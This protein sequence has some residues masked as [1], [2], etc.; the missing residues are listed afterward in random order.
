MKKFLLSVL[1]LSHA[2]GALCGEVINV[3]DWGIHPNTFEDATAKLQ[4]VI[5]ACRNKPDVI[6][7]FPPGRYDFWPDKAIQKE[8]YISNTSSESDCPSKVKNIGLLFE[9]LKNITVEGNGSLFVFHGKMITLAIDRSENIEI[10]NLSIDFER[11]SMSEITIDELY[12]DSLIASV[13]PDSRYAI[14]DGKIHFYGENWSMNDNY[15][16]ILTDTIQGTNVYTSWSPIQDAKAIERSP[17][18]LKFENKFDHTNYK[19]GQTITIRK[20]IRDHVGLF[21]NRSK[22]VRMENINIHYMHGLGVVSQFS[23]NL[24]YRHINITPSRQRTIASFADGMHFS[25]C[26]GHIEIDK[27][28]F[29]GLHDD[30]VNVH[31]TYLKIEKIDNPAKLTLRFMHAQ[32]YGMQAFFVND[33]VAFIRSET[34]QKTGF[35]VVT[36]VERLS[37]REVRIELDK[38]LPKEITMGDC[39]E[40]ITC[41]PS[42][43]ISNCRMEMTNTRGLLVTTPKKVV[44]ENNHFYRTGMYA[45]QIAADANSWYESGAV[46]DVVI[47]HNTF[48]ACGYNLYGGNNHY[49]IAIEPENHKRVKNHWVHRNI[50]IR[51]NVFKVYDNHPVIRARSVENLDFGNNTIENIPLI[52]LLKEQGEGRGNN[53]AFLFDNCTRIRIHDNTYKLPNTNIGIKCINMRKSDIKNSDNQLTINIL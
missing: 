32:T 31:G 30:P 14:I 49:A 26:K 37:D 44:I 42:L 18:K 52:P 3:A 24:T 10:R 33:T 40:N 36:N 50:Y 46:Q 29:K 39:I 16:S 11:P 25:G 9:N 34:L 5:A 53:A 17:F 4:Q 47:R 7:T 2:M 27:C 51:D 15:F 28:N 22:N 19:T 8:Y 6:L 41:I 48:E 12:P 45:I 38:P 23:E 43:R 1:L 13:H 35:A 20:H 21:V